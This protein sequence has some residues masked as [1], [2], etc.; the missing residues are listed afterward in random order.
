[1]T[2]EIEVKADSKLVEIKP[3][4]D[5]LIVFNEYR[6]EI[7]KGEKIKVHKMFLQNLKTEKVINN[8]T[9]V[10]QEVLRKL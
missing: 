9:K 4:K 2:K 10:L 8:N 7:K 6:Y 3:L 5:F 1:M